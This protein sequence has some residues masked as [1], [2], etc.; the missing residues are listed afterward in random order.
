VELPHLHKPG[1]TYFITFRMLDAVEPRAL[2][3]ASLEIDDM[4]QIAQANEPPPALGSCVLVNE[5]V[6]EMVQNA[7]LFF[8]GQRLW[9]WEWCIMPNHVHALVTPFKGYDLRSIIHS[10]K[11]FRAHRA[12]ELLDMRGAF[13]ERKSFD[14]ACRS[15]D[16]AAYFAGYIRQNP[17]TAGFCAASRQWR[18]GSAAIRHLAKPPSE[19][20]AVW[21]ETEGRRDR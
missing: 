18:W 9:L 6:G 1:C 8:H 3:T 13:W 12:N 7:L 21:W 20:S 4:E 19:K 10:W 16:H 11:S 2:P 14:H 15:I 5:K 17:V